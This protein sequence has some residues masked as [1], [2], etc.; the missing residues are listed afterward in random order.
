MYSGF[1]IR[2]CH[3]ARTSR[4]LARSSITSTGLVGLLFRNNF[5]TAMPW[6]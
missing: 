4:I 3:V 6:T 2:V 1:K 5:R